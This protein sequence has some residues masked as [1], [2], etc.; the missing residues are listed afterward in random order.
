MNLLDK[1]T[2]WFNLPKQIDELKQ[3]IKALEARIETLE[4]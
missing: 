4:N 2:S 3:Y 1:V